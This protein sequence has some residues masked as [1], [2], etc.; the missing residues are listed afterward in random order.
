[1]KS[2]RG[3]FDSN[4]DRHLARVAQLTERWSY[5]SEVEGL[6]PSFGT[7]ENRSRKQEQEHEVGSRRGGDLLP[8]APAT[9]S[10]LIGDSSR[11]NGDCLGSWSSQR[12]VDLTPRPDVRYA[13]ACRRPSMDSS[14]KVSDKLKHIGHWARVPD[15]GLLNRTYKRRVERHEVQLLRGLPRSLTAV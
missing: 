1:M 13:S 8:T 9:C 7:K 15:I 5:K 11:Q 4:S 2:P 12:R 3:W 10:C 14:S 6:S